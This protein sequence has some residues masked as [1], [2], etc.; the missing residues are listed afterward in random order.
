MGIPLP[1]RGKAEWVRFF[2]GVGLRPTPGWVPLLRWG[3][4]RWSGIPML[5]SARNCSRIGGRVGKDSQRSACEKGMSPW[6][7]F[8]SHERDS[9]ADTGWKPVPQGRRNQHY[10]SL[11]SRAQRR[12]RSNWARP[13]LRQV[14]IGTA[15][16]RPRTPPNQP[17]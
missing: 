9:R 7:L 8:D 11:M 1:R 5:M 10:S 2:P 6:R 3:I 14:S 17:Q 15:R 12:V 13:I 16:S 4:Y